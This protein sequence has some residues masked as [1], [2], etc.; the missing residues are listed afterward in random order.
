M[1]TIEEKILGYAK[2]VK[3]FRVSSVIK[4]LENK[5]SRQYISGK[6]KGL[7][8]KNTLV[9]SGSRG[10]YVYYA[11]PENAEYLHSAQKKIKK[12]L[13]N[14]NLKEHEILEDLLSQALFLTKLSDNV[15]SIFDYAFSEMLN[16]AIEHSKSPNIE[17]EV[18]EDNEFLVFTIRD[19]GIGVFRNVMQKRKLKNEL[20]A[21]QDLLKGKVTT[22]P[23]SHSGEG[24]FFTSKISDSFSEE[25]FEYKLKIDNMIKDIFVEN[26]KNIKGTK[27][28]F[29]IKLDSKKHLNDIF[30]QYQSDPK[31]YAFDKTD[32]HVKLYQMGTVH[33]SRSQAR[34]VL[35]NLE[36]F[37]KITMDF[38]GVPAIGQAFAD[39][40][41]RVFLSNHPEIS[42]EPINMNETVRFMI[43]RVEKPQ[44]EL[45][46]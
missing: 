40:V 41:F 13:K 22:E 31:N 17:V 15:R 24:I 21:I 28:T 32:V 4:L 45:F 43:E 18:S 26:I 46:D 25:S 9:R 33:V 10:A 14:Q 12:K 37:K 6:L 29:K 30:K 27:V 3:K 34:R 5:Y 38:E 16:N 8:L 35:S 2:T 20:E 44:P 42:I 19:F 23:K 36:K 7:S 1:I 39:E 11:L